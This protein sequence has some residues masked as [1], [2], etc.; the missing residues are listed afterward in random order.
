ML[1]IGIE[2]ID[3]V[4]WVKKE[5]FNINNFYLENI[6]N[7]DIYGAVYFSGASNSPVEGDPGYYRLA[8]GE[9]TELTLGYFV[10]AAGIEEIGRAHV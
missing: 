4:G 6:K 8:Q 9:Q 1:D 7:G 2:N 10:P 5:V 3:A